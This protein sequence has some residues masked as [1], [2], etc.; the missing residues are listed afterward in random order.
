MLKQQERNLFQGSALVAAV[1]QVM[2]MKAYL[3]FKIG[4]GSGIR[5]LDEGKVFFGFAWHFGLPSILW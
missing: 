4:A 1:T 5:A 3:S 2:K